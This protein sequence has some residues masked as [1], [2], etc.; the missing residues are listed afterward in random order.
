MNA[1][2]LSYIVA[3]LIVSGCSVSNSN[4]SLPTVTPPENGMVVPGERF[5]EVLTP[6]LGKTITLQGIVIRGNFSLAICPPDIRNRPNYGVSLYSS[7]GNQIGEE[8]L[9]WLSSFF[10][11]N[12]AS[13][14]V[15]GKLY[16]LGVIDPSGDNAEGDAFFSHCF[17]RDGKIFWIELINAVPINNREST[18]K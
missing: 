10:K 1:Q 7:Q 8:K 15:T 16:K 13:V 6:Y 11:S 12:S 5:E 18:P 2:L 17:G 4:V 14:S 3:I 9:H